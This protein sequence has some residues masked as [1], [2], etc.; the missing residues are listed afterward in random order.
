MTKELYFTPISKGNISILKF[1]CKCK[2]ETHPLAPVTVGLPASNNETVIANIPGEH[3]A[4]QSAFQELPQ[5]ILTNTSKS[6]DSNQPPL[7]STCSN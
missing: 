5:L 7:F 4:R 6:K 3:P 1:Y 2:T